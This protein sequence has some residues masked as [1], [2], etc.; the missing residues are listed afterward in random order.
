MILAIFTKPLM[1]TECRFSADMLSVTL[2][3]NCAECSY[4]EC[5]Y[6]VVTPLFNWSPMPNQAKLGQLLNM[7]PI[8]F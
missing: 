6:A 3:P 1:L 4:T 2:E 8:I 7:I 5:H